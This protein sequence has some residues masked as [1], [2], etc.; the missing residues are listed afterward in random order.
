MSYLKPILLLAVWAGVLLP[1]PAIGKFPFQPL[2]AM[3]HQELTGGSA[4][5]GQA[6]TG[7]LVDGPKRIAGTSSAGPDPELVRP[8]KDGTLRLRA[9]KGQ[10]IGPKIKY[11]PEWQAYGWFTAD[12]RIEWEVQAKKGR[13]DVYLEWSVSDQEAGKPF[14]FQAGDQQL[15]GTVAPSG[16]WEEFKTVHIGQLRLRSGR[17]KMVLKP[18]ARFEKGALLDLREIKLVPVRRKS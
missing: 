18:N 14:A 9:E 4:L 16:S 8:E 10:G 7:W 5:A 15:T 2:P 13:Y 6:V 12:D 11:M 3:V 1:E 17:Q